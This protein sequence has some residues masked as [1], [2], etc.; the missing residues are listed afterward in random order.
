MTTEKK[1]TGCKY[2]EILKLKNMLDEK[3]IPYDWESGVF[4][5]YALKYPSSRKMI[6]SVIQHDFSYGNDKNLLEIGHR[7]LNGGMEVEGYLTAE[8]VFEIIE[9][10]IA[11]RTDW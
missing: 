8:E 1:T 3:E 4:G 11:R 6:F 5:G 10:E 2:T 7:R 9:N